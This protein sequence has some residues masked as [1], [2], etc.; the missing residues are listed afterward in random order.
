M[1]DEKAIDFANFQQR[2][3][4]EE[5]IALRQ[6]ESEKLQSAKEA[7]EDEERRLHVATETAE[8]DQR[9]AG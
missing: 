3:Q 1:D 2:Q 5:R 9:K 4:R 6:G 7:A 8:A